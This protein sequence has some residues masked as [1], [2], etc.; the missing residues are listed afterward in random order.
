MADLAASLVELPVEFEISIA[1]V[2]KPSLT[3][4][5]VERRLLQFPDDP[6]WVTNAPTFADKARLFPGCR[7]VIGA[8]TALRLFDEKYYEDASARDAAIALL[9][10][11]DCR[12]IVFGRHVKNQFV[13]AEAIEIPE[14][15]V[16]LFTIVPESRFRDDISSTDLRRNS[17]SG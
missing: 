1:N 12:F 17:H 15:A 4:N 16:N 13:G 10:D 3:A 6:V 11:C 2:D 7:F 9:A 14:F 5:E 8:D